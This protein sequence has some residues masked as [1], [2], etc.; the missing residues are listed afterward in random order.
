MFFNE[1]V[2]EHISIKMRGYILLMAIKQKESLSN[3]IDW[4]EAKINI[5]D[6]G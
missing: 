3:G 4:G 2:V 5:T 1:S 6:S